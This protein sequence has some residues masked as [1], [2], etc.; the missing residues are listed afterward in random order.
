MAT[1]LALL[2]QNGLLIEQ[3]NLALQQNDLH[4]EKEINAYADGVTIVPVRLL[5]ALKQNTF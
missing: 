2:Y 5:E 1:L 4:K 3:N